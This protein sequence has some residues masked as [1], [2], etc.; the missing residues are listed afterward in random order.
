MG[1]YLAVVFSDLM[2]H[3]EVWNRMPRQ[4]MVAAIAEYRYLAD[5][6]VAH[7]G[8]LHREFTGDGHM[9]LFQSADAAVQFGLKLIDGWKTSRDSSPSLGGFPP[10]PLRVGCHFGECAQLDGDEAWVG[11]GQILAKRAESEAQ[12]DSL[13]VTENV[14]DLIDLPLYGFEAVGSFDLKGDHL[15]ERRLYR[16]LH[17]DQAALAAKPAAD[18]SA[19]DWFLQGVSFIGTEREN[20]AVEEEC[21]R[22]ALRLRPDYPE[23][24]NLYAALLRARGNLSEAA[25]HYREAL[26]LRP[27]YPEAHYNYASLLAAVGNPRAAAEHYQEAVAKRPDYADAHHGYAGLLA[28]LGEPDEAAEN[29]QEALRLRPDYPE[30]HN[31]YAI[32]LEARGAPEEAEEHYR[33]ALRLR[34]SYSE[35]HYNYALFLEDRGDETAAEEHYRQALREWPDYAEAHNNLAALLHRGGE[36]EEAREHYRHGL[37]LR[38][39]DPEVHYNYGLL[40]A[41][42]GD[43][44]EAERHF[45]IA[46]ELAPEEPVFRSAIQPPA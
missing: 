20:T 26:R 32:L 38:P 19:E 13:Y 1:S 6:L 45:R 24:H 7:Y 29:Y 37:R 17:F 34:P 39:E 31:N 15:A 22:E 40:A 44:E 42:Q 28:R 10:L 4:A 27:D 18:M 36:L 11:R 41:A 35:A 43:R 14:L 8:A 21:Y 23:A 33:Q 2:R 30:V 25:G 46:Y 16:V 9:V 3:S 5:G 12:P